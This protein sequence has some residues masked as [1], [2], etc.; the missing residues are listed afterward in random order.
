[1]WCAPSRTDAWPRVPSTGIFAKEAADSTTALKLRVSKT[2]M[3]DT[4][5][6]NA[7]VAL[8]F[9]RADLESSVFPQI[10]EREIHFIDRLHIQYEAVDIDAIQTRPG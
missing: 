7:A 9:Y 4:L 2:R 3:P 5:L 1:L 10:G 8:P 6:E